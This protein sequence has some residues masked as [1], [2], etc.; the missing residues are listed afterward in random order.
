[1]SSIATNDSSLEEIL[2]D[3]RNADNQVGKSDYIFLSI[4]VACVFVIVALTFVIYRLRVSKKK[5]TKRQ[6]M[7]RQGRPAQASSRPA[8]PSNHSAATESE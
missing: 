8:S 7:E 3:V 2:T 4:I 1:M 6:Q 5:W